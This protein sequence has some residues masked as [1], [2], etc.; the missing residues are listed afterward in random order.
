MAPFL[1]LFPAPA[2][3]GLHFTRFTWKMRSTHLLIYL[4][5]LTPRSGQFPC[6]VLVAALNSLHGWMPYWIFVFVC[7]GHAAPNRM[8]H[9]MLVDAI[10]RAQAVERLVDSPV[11]GQLAMVLEKAVDDT[12]E[13]AKA[14]RGLPPLYEVY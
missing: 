9:G 13:W 8:V 2:G 1:P 7:R 14:M 4:A 6:A 10:R 3:A 5:K 11:H 12:C